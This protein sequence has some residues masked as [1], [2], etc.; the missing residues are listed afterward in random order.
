MVH[1]KNFISPVVSILFLIF[2]LILI[3]IYSGLFH[4]EATS[5]LDEPPYHM[6]TVTHVHTWDV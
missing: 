5:I 4:Q 3:L 6:H 2:C 1:P